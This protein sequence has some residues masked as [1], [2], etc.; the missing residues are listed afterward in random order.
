LSCYQVQE[1]IPDKENPHD[2]QIAEVEGD[3]DVKGP[4]IEFQVIY[5]PIKVKKVNIGIAKHPKMASIGDYWDDPIVE[6]ITELLREYNDLF[7]TKFT[8]MN[9]IAGELGEMKIAL[10]TKV[11]PIKQQPYRLNPI[12]KQKFKVDID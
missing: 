8:E 12:Y 10:R 3:K 1:D 2:I 11:R 7:P 6:S 5:A 9:V 4:Q